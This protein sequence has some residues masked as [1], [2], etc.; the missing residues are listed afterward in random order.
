MAV[1]GGELVVELAVQAALTALPGI[2]AVFLAMRRGVEDE[3]ALLGIALAGSGLSAV[4]GFGSYY[5]TPSLGPPTAYAMV[6]ASVVLI[7]WCW[8]AARARPALRRRL[9]VPLLLWLLGSAFIVFFGFLH[10]GTEAPLNMAASRFSGQLPSDNDIPHYFADWFAAHG[11]SGTPPPFPPDWLS[12]DRP[13]LQTGYVLA[14]RS[15]GWDTT[16][17]HYQLIGVL[18]QELWIVGMW[19]LL[20]AARLRPTTRSLIMVATIFSDVAILHGFF[21]W[22][23]LLAASFLLGALAL[24][25][26]P[27]APSIRGAP[28]TTPIFGF[29]CA[30]AY[31]S[32]GASVF[33]LI[34]LAAIAV[35]RGLP[36]WRWLGAGVAAALVPVLLWSAYQHYADPPGNRLEKWYLA[37]VTEIDSRGVG[38]T[39]ADSYSEVGLGGALHDKLENL[40]SM[41][42]NREAGENLENAVSDA[43][44]GDAEGA[45]QE[46]RGLRFFYL[47]PSLG[48]FV[49]GLPFLVVAR[50]R[51]R[52][53]GRDWAFA[54]LLLVFLGV[55]LA[56]WGLLFFGDGDARTIVHQGSLAMPLLAMA[57]IV[58][59]LRAT[60]PRLA[61]AL[62]AANALTVLCIYTPSLTPLPGTSYWGVAAAGTAAA[63]AGIVY[64]LLVREAGEPEPGDG[65]ASPGVAESA[66]VAGAGSVAR[67]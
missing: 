11:H 33:G 35:W 61:G 15:F 40:I 2:A 23:K 51:G 46:L 7:A 43:A 36:P 8:P 19:A 34:P 65:A 55:G 1:T 5:A 54:K 63:L 29:L 3:P 39:V 14:Q 53:E 32:H 44:D 57:A 42:G 52:I 66:L 13:P 22:P 58:A 56:S 21:I 24:L 10:G 67:R 27:R 59:G 26:S 18:V 9:S 17:L 62:V 48:L 50:A 25:A 47:L 64:L 31:L 38:E 28:W 12:S 37:G 60:F 4:L 41:T 45:I 30:L 6:L 20:A 49:I 16:L